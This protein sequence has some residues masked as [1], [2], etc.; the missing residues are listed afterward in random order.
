MG[1]QWSAKEIP[2]SS[3]PKDVSSC[4]RE[5]AEPA[6]ECLNRVQCPTQQPDSRSESLFAVGL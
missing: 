2:F 6:P 5:A 3:T 4:A 1:L